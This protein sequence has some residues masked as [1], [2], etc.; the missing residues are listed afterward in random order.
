MT[1][2]AVPNVSRTPASSG[3][4]PG[5]PIANAWPTSSIVRTIWVKLR[6]LDTTAALV[7][8]YPISRHYGAGPIAVDW[9]P[10]SRWIAYNG[11]SGITIAATVGSGHS[12]LLAPVGIAP[13]WRPVPH[14]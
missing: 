3:H 7:V 13:A 4:T 14:P 10:D 9:S 5:R 6:I 1:R 11:D 2:P 8:T 12:Y